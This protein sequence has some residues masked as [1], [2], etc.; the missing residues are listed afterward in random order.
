MS[1]LIPIPRKSAYQTFFLLDNDEHIQG[2]YQWHQDLAAEA[3][4]ILCDFEV[5]FRSKFHHVMASLNCRS[6]RDD[7][8]ISSTVRIS[9]IETLKREIQ[10]AKDRNE[11]FYPDPKKL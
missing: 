9:L 1:V 11:D 10:E 8:I 3:F 4:L 6:G 7:W 2:A 5:L